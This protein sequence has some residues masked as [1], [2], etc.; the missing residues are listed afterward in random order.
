MVYSRIAK[1]CTHSEKYGLACWRVW[2]GLGEVWRGTTAELDV[3]FRML[4]LPAAL[5]DKLQGSFGDTAVL[6]PFVLYINLQCAMKYTRVVAIA[7]HAG[8]V[9][10][11][12]C[13]GVG[14]GSSAMEIEVMTFRTLSTCCFEEAFVAV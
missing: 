14:M 5:F 8:H 1:P 3:P 9:C 2:A 13:S 4:L 7:M 10:D 6:P 12:T 11:F